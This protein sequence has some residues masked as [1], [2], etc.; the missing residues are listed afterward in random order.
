MSHSHAGQ[1]RDIDMPPW[2]IPEILSNVRAYANQSDFAALCQTSKAMSSVGQRILYESIHLD[3]QSQQRGSPS[4]LCRTLGERATLGINVRF[5]RVELSQKDRE[6]VANVRWDNMVDQLSWIPKLLHPC[7]NLLRAC[8]NLQTFSIYLPHQPYQPWDPRNPF[9]QIIERTLPDMRLLRKLEVIVHTHHRP[10]IWPGLYD[11]NRS[12]LISALGLKS[13]REISLTLEEGPTKLPRP[14]PTT[15][16]TS[17]ITK[18]SLDQSYLGMRTLAK[19]LCS[20]PCLT[21]L[22]LSLCYAVHDAPHGPHLGNHLDCDELGKALVHRASTLKN[23]VIAVDFST[24]DDQR[25]VRA[26]GTA[27]EEWGP[28]HSASMRPLAC[29][30]SLQ[31]APEIILGWDAD[32][33]ATLSELLPDSIRHLHFRYD[34]GA[35]EN[36][37]WEFDLFCQLVFAYIDTSPRSLERIVLTCFSDEVEE[38]GPLLKL[39]RSSCQAHQIEFDLMTVG[40]ERLRTWSLL[41]PRR[42]LAMPNTLPSM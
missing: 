25:D 31:L 3:W 12:L 23:L 27:T 41:H 4:L 20:L 1:I 24:T 15:Y 2:Y 36:S 14:L 39:M 11:V 29:L 18:L 16:P 42:P 13:L 37:P 7:A 33:S 8:A 22:S 6:V 26:G 28:L 32:Q 35:W 9:I 5:L 30:T 34:F 17:Y 19:I 38:M 10:M 40:G 21:D